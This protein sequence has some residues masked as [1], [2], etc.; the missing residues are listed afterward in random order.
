MFKYQKLYA[1]HTYVF[2]YFVHDIFL[3]EQQF[4]ADS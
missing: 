4:I 1:T 2:V 3:T